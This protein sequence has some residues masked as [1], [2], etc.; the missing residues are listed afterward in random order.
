MMGCGS[1]L[2]AKPSQKIMNQFN[3]TFIKAKIKELSSLDLKVQG[4]VSVHKD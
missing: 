3:E 2:C 1:L 4:G